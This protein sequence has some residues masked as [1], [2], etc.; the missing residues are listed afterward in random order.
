MNNHYFKAVTTAVVV[1]V[2]LLLGTIG[3][4]YADQLDQIHGINSARTQQA[5]A[6][7]AKVDK[8]DDER[9][10][11]L[12]QYKATHKIIDGLRVYNSQ[13][14]KQIS[15]QQRQ[16]DELEA[17]IVQ[18]TEMK[19]QITPLMLR[20][21]DGL[22]QFINLDVPFHSQERQERLAFIKDALDNPAIADSEKFRQV[23]EG[24]QIENEY[25]RKTDAYTDIATIDGA[26]VNVNILRVGRIALLA[27]TKD[28]KTTLVWDK[29]AGESGAWMKLPPAYRNPVRQGIRIARKQAT[30]D[31]LLLPI[32]A[33]ESAQ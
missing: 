31:M 30:T 22:E 13:L 33:P 18:T 9:L 14:E 2:S 17:S 12:G 8:L 27:Q 24:Y 3:Q 21:V 7:Q 15:A 10:S 20:M 6:S 4:G 19:R 29:K 16:L 23:L 1:T 5:Q 32:A 26:Q 25:G 28:E 11:L